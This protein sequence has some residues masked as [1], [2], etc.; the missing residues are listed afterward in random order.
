MIRI[1]FEIPLPSMTEIQTVCIEDFFDEIKGGVTFDLGGFSMP[2]LM[3]CLFPAV[4]AIEAVLKLI[5]TVTDFLLVNVGGAI[6]D[7]MPNLG[8]LKFSEVLSFDIKTLANG[9]PDI[10]GIFKGFSQTALESVYKIPLLIPKYIRDCTERLQFI[11]DLFLSIVLGGARPPLPP[12]PESNPDIEDVLGLMSEF[13]GSAIPDIGSLANFDLSEFTLAGVELPNIPE[14]PFR[15]LK[16]L[17]L[18]STARF[19][20]MLYA[21]ATLPLTIITDFIAS[22]KDL[23]EIPLPVF[24]LEF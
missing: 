7:I 18:E 13:F 23:V 24:V 3:P 17:A 12:I 21:I 16:V 1:E 4:F 2:D 11:L 5:G 8:D 9:L 19:S 14:N 22:I 15:N 6:D 20:A 10:G